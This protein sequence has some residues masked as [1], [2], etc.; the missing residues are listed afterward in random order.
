MSSGNLKESFEVESKHEAFYTG[1]NILW[2]ED[3]ENLFCQNRDFISVVSVSKGAVKLTLGK[4]NE[5]EEEDVINSFTTSKDGK[6]IVTHHKSSLFKLWNG[7]DVK[8]TKVW[9]SIHNGP[10]AAIALTNSGS[11]MASGGVDGS[12][13]LWDFE[14]HTCTHNLKGAQGVVSIIC[15]HPDV[16]KHLV[17][18]SADDYVIH[19][20]NT[21]TGQKEVTL[22]GHFSKVTSLSFH[23]D[24]VHAL[25]SG[26]DKVL[27]L[28]D[29]VKKASVRILPVYE[30][31][32][33]AFII[34]DSASLPVSKAK[35]KSSIYAASAGE[36]G[37]VKIWEMKSGRMLYEQTNSLIPAAKEENGLAVKHLLY[38]EES[39]SVGLV[40]TS[41]NI[42]VYSLEKFECSK[43]LIGYI[44]EIL[45]I[46]YIGSN[47]SHLAVATN[48][49]DIK[50]YELSTMSCQ[51][52]CGHTN[53]VLSLAST[54][55]N[56]NILLSSDKDNCVR[57][58]LMDEETRTVNCIGSGTR[59]TAAVGCVAFSQTEAKFFVSISQDSCLK[60]WDLPENI[61]Y[62]GTQVALNA[63]HTVAAHTKDINSV[64]VSPN[65][66][67]IATGSQD[68]TAKLWSAD[69]LQQLGVFR[70]HRRGVW[71]VRFSPIDQVLA[72]SSADC[73]IK[74]WSLGELN[75][76][77][78]FEGHESAVLKMEF[79][80]RGMQIISSGADG[81]LKLWSVKSAECNA[82]LDQHN[83]RVWSIA[84]NKN[85]THLVSGG[86][87][88]LL[89]I[90]RDTTQE[91]K[92]KAIALQ[93]ELMKDE[94]KLANCLQAQKLTKALRLALK[95]QK[96]MHVLRIIE[97]LVK[98]GEEDLT[99][100]IVDLKPSQQDELL[101]CAVIW[102]T[103]ARNFQVAQLVINTLLK[104]IGLENLQSVDLKEKLQSMIPYTDRHLKRL[105]QHYQDLHLLS[106]TINS[107][108]AHNPAVE[109]KET[110]EV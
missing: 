103:N 105:T 22:E 1:G 91:N 106:Y 108:K 101:K 54:P 64:T 35:N 38:N 42:L 104:E 15:Y 32:E 6:F 34:P 43:Q 57:L 36:K 47:N 67:L 53:I 109:G 23:E 3:S 87:D 78:T 110:A 107:M 60:M 92:A 66:K 18:A 46:A 28:W 90:W 84:V 77:K 31:I 13:R 86:S 50:L 88:S 102:N 51:I 79:L 99:T 76:L 68:K 93:E 63:T 9:K 25:S 65:D 12:V 14:H 80:S 37:V 69:N 96:P 44:D 72:T 85:E 70:G 2:S 56:P 41:H 8:P 39:N 62:T 48:T 49:S 75:C 19:G 30:C 94:Q 82:T 95:L 55:A 97:A 21:Q 7:T 73:T 10:V 16:E 58:W 100:T 71:C 74:L 24:G 27:I 59:H 20:W 83:N 45:D 29:I 17:F 40:S 4:A 11:N 26:R 61:A 5:N 33:G 89:V 81:L 52:L 98:K